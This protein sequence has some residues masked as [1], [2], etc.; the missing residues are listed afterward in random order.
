MRSICSNWMASST[1]PAPQSAQMSPPTT[2][3]A[4]FHGRL[5]KVAAFANA[6]P[7][8]RQTAASWPATA[9]SPTTPHES[10]RMV[11]RTVSRAARARRDRARVGPAQQPT[12]NAE[13]QCGC[14]VRRHCSTGSKASRD[15]DRLDPPIHLER[16][17]IAIA[18]SGA[19][20]AL[21]ASEILWAVG[22]TLLGEIAWGGKDDTP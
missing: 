21:M 16:P 20:D 4:V 17:S 22:P 2:V 3:C 12:G 11:A 18:V 5:I 7:G 9:W 13:S 14:R 10:G 1:T 19:D 8:N 6:R 15:F